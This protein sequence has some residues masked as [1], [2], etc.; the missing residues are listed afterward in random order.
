MTMQS[1]SQKKTYPLLFSPLKV[2]SQTLRNRL[3]MGSMHTGLEDKF[4]KLTDLAK[5]YEERAKGGVGLIITGGFAPNWRGWLLP[6][7][8]TLNSFLQVAKHRE[9]TDAVHKHGAKIALQILHAGRYAYHPFSVAPSAIKAPIN[10][11][12]P[13]A[14]SDRVVQKTIRDFA[15]AAKLAQRAGYDGVE[16]MGSEGYLINEFLSEKTNKRTDRWGGSLENRMRFPIEII[17]AVREAVGPE[18]I[19]IYRLS[20]L[21]L[22]EKGNSIQDSIVLAKEIEKAGASIISTG[23]GWHEAR[24]PTIATDVPRAAFTWVTE[25]IKKQVKVPVIASNRMNMPETAEAVLNSGQGDLIS[26]ARPWLA[27]AEFGVKAEAGDSQLI[28]TCIACNQACL[29][30]IFANKQATCLVNPRAAYESKI[31][32]EK[33]LSKKKVAVIGAGPSGLSAA[34]TLAERGHEVHLFDQNREI[35]GQFNLAKRIPGKSEFSE[36]LRYFTHRLA[37][38][39]VQLHLGKKASAKDLAKENFDDIVVATGIRPRTPKIEGLDLALKNKKALSYIQVIQ[40]EVEV[41]DCVAIIGAGGI[42][43]D[44]AKFVLEKMKTK[45]EKNSSHEQLASFEKEWGIS[46]NPQ[47]AGGLQPAKPFLLGENNPCGIYLMQRKAESLGKNLGKTTGWIHRATLKNAGVKMLSGVE[48]KRI[49]D[50]GLLIAQNTSSA[51]ASTLK[52][53]L[54]NVDQIIICAGQESLNELKQE[55]EQSLVG[56]K[57]KVHIIGGA[58]VALELDAKAAIRDGLDVGLLI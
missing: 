41:Q 15:S 27:D 10:P 2:G 43:F 12:K 34:A 16:I 23:I 24:V 9:V 6:F 8:S 49:V 55:L 13:K 50:E 29:D 36:T 30:H 25:Q 3:V 18:F 39:Q 33:A 7:A 19:I 44:V 17:R 31:Q 58:R 48:Y 14:M 51:G 54:L 22:V 5:F 40:G 20:M 1:D 21:E 38:L 35:G 11:F 56:Q 52:E 28:N 26:M 37:E 32:I 57:T 47:M 42:G 45:Y 4:L 46:R 53:Q